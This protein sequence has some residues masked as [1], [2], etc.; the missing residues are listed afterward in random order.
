MRA[1]QITE[2]GGP[3]VMTVSEVAKPSPQ[4]GEVLVK[5]YVMLDA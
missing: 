5:V 1:I 4:A 3:E 2:V